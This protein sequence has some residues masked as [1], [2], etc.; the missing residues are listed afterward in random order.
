[1]ALAAIAVV[2]LQRIA[3]RRIAGDETSSACDA[4]RD[5][6]AVAEQRPQ[7]GHG[8]RVIILRDATRRAVRGE[9]RPGGRHW[10]RHRAGAANGAGCAGAARS[11]AK[12]RASRRPARQLV[13]F[14]VARVAGVSAHPLEAHVVPR[15]LGVE[16]FP[17]VQILRPAP[18]L[19]H[20]FDQVLAVAA[21]DHGHAGVEGAQRF[22]RRHYFHPIVGGLRIA[23]A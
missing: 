6:F 10:R 3:L 13:G 8:A 23:A 22:D 17:Q 16:L 21:K 18:A 11:T 9:S 14:F 4:S 7:F 15:N 5:P 2:L 1:V 20:R 19:V 12:G